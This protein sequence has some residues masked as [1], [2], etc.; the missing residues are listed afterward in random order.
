MLLSLRLFL[1]L[2]SIGFFVHRKDRHLDI[3]SLSQSITVDEIENVIFFTLHVASR[4]TTLYRSWRIFYKKKVR[5]LNIID[6]FGRKYFNNDASV[7]QDMTAG[8]VLS[9]FNLFCLQ[10]HMKL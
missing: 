6:L 5:M 2:I 4:Q 3:S 7:D 8:L 10:M 9:Y 1:M